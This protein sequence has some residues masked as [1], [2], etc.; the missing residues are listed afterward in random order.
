MVHGVLESPP[1]LSVSRTQTT[2]LLRDRWRTQ[3]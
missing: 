3:S 2:R 1:L